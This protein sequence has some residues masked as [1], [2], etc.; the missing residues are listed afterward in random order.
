MEENLI[1]IASVKLPF[2]LVRASREGR[3]VVFAGAGVSMQRPTCL[4]N[5]D[6]LV[7]TIRDEVDPGHYLRNRAGETPER[8][9]GYL[10]EQGRDIY[11]ACASRL[12]VVR[13]PSSL[14]ENILTSFGNPSAARIVTTNFDEC[15]ELAY[16]T[17][18]P[19]FSSS[20]LDVYVAPT[21]PDPAD[22]HGIV[23][24]HGCVTRPND[25]VLTDADFGQAYMADGW[26]SRF[27]VKL[28]STY[29]V[30]FVGYSCNDALVDYLTKSL[31]ISIRGKAYVMEHDSASF[32]EWQRRGV[33]PIG[34]NAF[35]DLPLLFR[36]WTSIN[37]ATETVSEVRRIVT[38]M[39]NDTAFAFW[40][41][42]LP[43][44]V[45]G[46]D[47]ELLRVALD[48]RTSLGDLR[49]ADAFCESAKTPGWI[50]WLIRNGCL[51]WL[52]SGAVGQ[53]EERLIAWLATESGRHQG[54]HAL[55]IGN[56]L[57]SISLSSNALG[58]FINVLK[59]LDNVDNCVFLYL[60]SLE[61][62]VSISNVS[63]IADIALMCDSNEAFISM[64]RI[65]LRLDWMDEVAAKLPIDFPVKSI[66]D[67]VI[68]VCRDLG[69]AEELLAFC[70]DRVGFAE[71]A[72]QVI[73]T[74]AHDEMEQRFTWYETWG[75]E[76]EFGNIIHFCSKKVSDDAPT[77]FSGLLARVFWEAALAVE[78][79]LEVDLIGS[80]LC[81]SSMVVRRLAVALE[82][83]RE[84]D[85]NT[86]VGFIEENA[87]ELTS[88]LGSDELRE[89]VIDVFSSENKDIRERVL[90]VAEEMSHTFDETE[91]PNSSRGP[92]ALAELYASIF[93]LYP[94]EPL[95]S[96]YA[97]R[98]ADQHP[99]LRTLLT[100]G[101]D[102]AR[103][104]E[105]GIGVGP[106][107]IDW[108]LKNKYSGLSISDI[109]Q[110]TPYDALQLAYDDVGEAV[111]LLKETVDKDGD[112]AQ[113]V[114][115]ALLG[116]IPPEDAWRLSDDKYLDLLCEASGY[117]IVC[118]E[119]VHALSVL[120]GC[121]PDSISSDDRLLKVSSALISFIN[122]CANQAEAIAYRFD[123]KNLKIEM[124]AQKDAAKHAAF[125]FMAIVRAIASK[126]DESPQSSSAG[127]FCGG[128]VHV[129]IRQSEF[130]MDEYASA[131]LE[132]A[133]AN[134]GSLWKL[135]ERGVKGEL[136]PLLDVSQELSIDAWRGVARLSE[137]DEKTWGCISHDYR[138][139][140]SSTEILDELT[141]EQKRKLLDL[142]ITCVLAYVRDEEKGQWIW[143]GVRILP[144]YRD[145]AVAKCN[146]WARDRWSLEGRHQIP[147]WLADLLFQLLVTKTTTSSSIR[148]VASALCA[149]AKEWNEQ[150]YVAD[151]GCHP[152]IRVLEQGCG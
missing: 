119:S 67:R 107:S 44:R 65:C 133:L 35:S 100:L 146:I 90:H 33:T 70:R 93:E 152:L 1:N 71:Y 141:D 32:S 101:T 74:Y 41:L 97:T 20:L 103:S 149:E 27:L 3:L 85:A 98:L 143:D 135:D 49:V 99:H 8:Y 117:D 84:R 40:H 59:G 102:G 126:M 68:I 127:A 89:M 104:E 13:T 151:L 38:S 130:D 72:G 28:F 136:L 110:E 36:Q 15:F 92:G 96:S 147:T 42:G 87:Y 11:E 95:T 7:S 46:D 128:L 140:F 129:L 52:S 26:A 31:S 77:T 86:L 139:M 61:R 118:N 113:S 134:V 22:F 91:S 109:S 62:G 9:L 34:F 138:R 76:H 5:F 69:N 60:P 148:A 82:C 43:V 83:T 50:P 37:S 111:N 23:H 116:V 64:L 80:A 75:A 73:K 24:L 30:L 14:H 17:L 88:V 57:R 6:D 66:L 78:S 39:T 45:S 124:I 132:E 47:G 79:S 122:L 21:L 51:D 144:T 2:S 108:M 142:Y 120:V 18:L 123:E 106:K 29:T 81:S 54:L 58:A 131:F 12:G 48:P 112:K 137:V 25:Q 63:G 4:P 121:V 10:K 145:D 19:S 53:Y 115:I 94:N 105:M 114:V 56:H 125:D 16:E 55:R 150:A